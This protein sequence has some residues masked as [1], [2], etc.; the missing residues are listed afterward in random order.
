MSSLVRLRIV[1]WLINSSTS[2]NPSLFMFSPKSL[3]VCRSIMLILS[4]ILS[5]RL[6]GSAFRNR[7]ASG[8]FLPSFASCI[9]AVVSQFF[10]LHPGRCSSSSLAFSFIRSPHLL[11]FGS[12]RTSPLYSTIVVSVAGTCTSSGESVCVLPSSNVIKHG[13]F[14]V[15]PRNR[16]SY[17][18]FAFTITP[19]LS[20]FLIGSVPH[21]LCT[22]AVASVGL[23]H[24]PSCGDL[25]R[26]PAGSHARS[27][28]REYF[29]SGGCALCIALI[30]SSGVF[31]T[32][33]FFS[34]HRVPFA[35]NT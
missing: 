2:T 28:G 9:S 34:F 7:I 20:S 6:I 24:A 27:S 30:S 33:T 1:G 23:S 25:V 4:A 5:C 31:F 15:S 3:A 21:C 14:C 12:S 29:P 18:S 10:T 17:I 8:S 16:N 26:A 19:L 22:S 11:R 13:C 32:I 35:V